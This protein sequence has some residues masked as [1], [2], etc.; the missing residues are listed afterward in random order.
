M[1]DASLSLSLTQIP[2]SSSLHGSMSVLQALDS[3]DPDYTIQDRQSALATLIETVST[4]LQWVPAQAGLA[5][6]EKVDRLAKAGSDCL[7]RLTF[8]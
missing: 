6:N 1:S 3:D 4:T 8:Q 7:S 2:L 5:G